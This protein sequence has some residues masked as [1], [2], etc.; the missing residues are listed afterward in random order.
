MT[1]VNHTGRVEEEALQLRDLESATTILHDWNVSMNR[2]VGSISE[3]RLTNLTLL[4]K[5]E[6]E[7]ALDEEEL[8]FSPAKRAGGVLSS[9]GEGP[10][11]RQQLGTSTSS[12]KSDGS[13]SFP[14]DAEQ[15]TS[16]SSAGGA[17]GGTSSSGVALD[18][19]VESVLP[20]G[21]SVAANKSAPL[22]PTSSSAATPSSS[23][24]L[25]NSA[26]G[27][28]QAQA[29]NASANG[30]KEQRRRK[31]TFRHIFLKSRA[32]E[33]AFRAI[34]A[35]PELQT[36]L[37]QSSAGGSGAEAGGDQPGT[38]GATA[39]DLF[40][41]QFWKLIK[42]VTVPGSQDLV[43][44]LVALMGA[45]PCSDS[46]P[47]AFFAVLSRL[48]EDWRASIYLV[49]RTQLQ[50]QVQQVQ[51]SLTAGGGGAAGGTTARASVSAIP[52][53]KP[54]QI[55]GTWSEQNKDAN[56]SL[57]LLNLLTD[58]HDCDLHIVQ[59][60]T[61]LLAETSTVVTAE[62]SSTTSLTG[63][64]STC[65]PSATTTSYARS[66]SSILAGIDT[67]LQNG[68]DQR[69]K[70][71]QRKESLQDA[72]KTQ[73]EELGTQLGGLT[74]GKK[75]VQDRVAELEKQKEELEK[76]LST[77][78]TELSELKQQIAR[79]EH[80]ED[81]LKKESENALVFYEE[82][83]QS[84]KLQD[85]KF[86]RDQALFHA[87]KQMCASG[88]KTQ[89]DTLHL[90]IEERK[91]S[92][93]EVYTGLL[94]AGEKHLDLEATRLRTAMTLVET[95]CVAVYEAAPAVSGA[96]GGGQHAPPLFAAPSA[97]GTTSTSEAAA[98]G[99]MAP[100][101]PPAPAPSRPKEALLLD[102][103]KAIAVR[104]RCWQE[105]ERFLSKYEKRLL[106]GEACAAKIQ[107]T[108]AD[109]SQHK[110]KQEPVIQ[111]AWE[112]VTGRAGGP[113]GPALMLQQQHQQNQLPASAAAAGKNLLGGITTGGEKLLGTA[114]QFL[115]K[116]KDENFPPIPSTGTT[117]T[118][119]SGGGPPGGTIAA[120]KLSSAGTTG[121]PATNSSAGSTTS[122]SSSASQSA[123][124]SFASSFSLSQ[125]TSD[126]NE[127]FFNN[128]SNPAS[129]PPS[130]EAP[131]AGASSTKL[132]AASTTP[133]VPVPVLQT[134][135]MA[136]VGGGTPSSSPDKTVVLEAPKSVDL[137]NQQPVEFHSI[138]TPTTS[139]KAAAQ[140][141]G[142][143]TAPAVRPVAPPSG[144]VSV[145][146]ST[147]TVPPPPAAP[148][149]AATTSSSSAAK[150]TDKLFDVD[151]DDLFSMFQAGL[152]DIT[153]K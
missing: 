29:A 36:A 86:L 87:I 44:E 61:T 52:S 148:T 66:W 42:A 151:D 107:K 13:A 34:H 120:G 133:A 102:L 10:A 146:A 147:S 96:G 142:S 129:S 130:K 139:P 150:T 94:S 51:Q 30:G 108:K 112:V 97:G 114:G 62:G 1:Q 24:N 117:M 2:T 71:Q 110:Q 28:S 25:R 88:G 3:E 125:V 21:P 19:N 105:L 64:T 45:I 7:M 103:K 47:D 111:A 73:R 54:N 12:K 137:R 82:N 76:Q 20:S 143:S 144:T 93:S 101:H 113:G 90:A 4:S 68:E 124:S 14:S 17:P 118:S 95:C 33:Y 5:T 134:G 131:T 22:F 43:K 80:S 100:Q 141:G 116:L 48:K 31:V 84:L 41:Q 65:S 9:E 136:P 109:F 18:P 55:L 58:A 149:A 57:L 59:R 16:K 69:K 98:T 115:S 123:A 85:E 106:A 89:A 72:K 152:D 63:T 91:K 122:A 104:D 127:L 99:I 77:V 140:S 121:T 74:D 78:V 23:S 46:L 132:P 60:W 126:I 153:K 145:V 50:D 138:G 81:A 79:V 27:T 135:N 8:P 26:G 40:S 35:T 49:E 83:L 53:L 11:A 70:M 92:A 119:M 128:S 6:D 38:N 39:A 67:S 75:E 56:K 37:Q 15:Q 32:L